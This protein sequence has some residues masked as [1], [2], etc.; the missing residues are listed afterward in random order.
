LSGAIPFRSGDFVW[1]R[2]PFE[3]DPDE[4]GLVR[5]AACVIAA[6]SQ[7]QAGA[8]T[9]AK[10]PARGLVVGVYTSSKVKKYGDALPVGVIQVGREQASRLGDQ[11]AFFIDVRRRAFLP[12]TR[13]F[14]EGTAL[15]KEILTARSRVEAFE[16]AM[17]DLHIDYAAQEQE[18]HHLRLE[19]ARAGA[20]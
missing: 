3:N 15:R 18:V 12:Y 6:F 1:T 17:R 5:H 7:Q 2:F 16:E 14:F 8:A 19:V 20:E 10:I 11:V 4:P 13:K 9:S